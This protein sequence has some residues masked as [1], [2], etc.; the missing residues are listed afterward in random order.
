LL[1]DRQGL[2]DR[3]R[4]L[5]EAAGGRV[6]FLQAHRAGSVADFE[7][8]V[9]PRSPQAVQFLLERVL[10]EGPLQAI[11]HAWGLDDVA[12]DGEESSFPLLSDPG[13]QGW[14]GALHLARALSALQLRDPPR[15]VFLTRRAQRVEPADSVAP[16]Q[17]LLW[18]LG[19]TF[20]TEYPECRCLRVDVS[21]PASANEATALFGSILDANGEDQIALRQTRHYVPRLVHGALPSDLRDPV[22]PR[23]D[24]TYV[25]TGGL[26]GLGFAAGSWLASLGAGHLALMGRRI[27]LTA[28]QREAIA[29]MERAGTRVTL[30]AVDVTDAEQ[31]VEALDRL[32]REGPPLR[33]VVHAAGAFDVGLLSEQSL[34]RFRHVVAA[35]VEGGWNLH[36][37]TAGDPL[38]F[39]VLYSSVA[40]LL[41]SFSLGPYAA[42]NAFLDGL[43]NFRRSAGLVATSINWASF[44]DVGLATRPEWQRYRFLNQGVG[45]LDRAEGER[46]LEAV[47]RTG[48]GQLGAASLDTRKLMEVF[49]QVSHWPYLS[50]LVLGGSDDSQ[51]SSPSCSGDAVLLGALEGQVPRIRIEVMQDHVQKQVAEVMRMDPEAIERDVPLLQLGLDSLMSMEI[52]SALESSIGKV[53][54]PTLVWTYPTVA[55]LAQRCLELLD[56]PAGEESAVLAE[57]ET[58]STQGSSEEE[59]MSY[60]DALLL[61]DEVLGKGNDE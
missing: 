2:A 5:V 48:P 38:E 60:E 22:V 23:K 30:T 58:E 1:A 55:A 25:V 29:E 13:N 42:G 40:S 32:R 47:L 27:E 37:H 4:R 45:Q 61:I 26:G 41:G 11:V 7:R 59:P 49:P 35:K 34:D 24:G 3:L 31:L 52:R 44:H 28:S 46:V 18:G 57:G 51:P 50:E 43:A 15:V 19:G 10:S 21:D 56:D 14:T 12:D 17:A 9:D 54:P 53:L 33:G 36:R 8:S 20:F 6:V 16:V 39:F